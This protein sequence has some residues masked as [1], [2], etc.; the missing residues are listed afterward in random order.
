MFSDNDINSEKIQAPACMLALEPFNDDNVNEN[1]L[2]YEKRR[3]DEDCQ[4][5]KESCTEYFGSRRGI[6]NFLDITESFIDNDTLTE[7]NQIASLKGLQCCGD[8][9]ENDPHKQGSDDELEKVALTKSLNSI[10]L[11]SIHSSGSIGSREGFQRLPWSSGYYGGQDD[12][13]RR[14]RSPSTDS[15]TI[16]RDEMFNRVQTLVSRMQTR[17]TGSQITDLYASLTGEDWAD[18]SISSSR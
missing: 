16:E 3:R 8:S 5:K 18:A 14:M 6:V 10:V 7:E 12:H 13:G 17:R 4:I 15:C 2:N 9:G 1:H 11:K